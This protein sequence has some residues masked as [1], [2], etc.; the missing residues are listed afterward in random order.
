M[1]NLI[2]FYDTWDLSF[3]YYLSEVD[4]F[5][6][7]LDISKTYYT[8]VNNVLEFYNII[9]YVKIKECNLKNIYKNKIEFVYKQINSFIV[10]LEESNFKKYLYKTNS[11]YYEDFWK[12][13]DDNLKNLNLSPLF[14]KKIIKMKKCWIKHI[15]ECKNIVKAYSV[16]I[17]PYLLKYNL[18]YLSYFLK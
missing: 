10:Q 3:G 1:R 8:N 6:K 9:K 15:L 18:K 11:I 5:F 2:K 12:L 13:I 14:F 7:K 4:L 17:K 16:I